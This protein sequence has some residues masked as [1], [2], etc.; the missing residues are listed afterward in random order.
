[1]SNERKYYSPEEIRNILN[2]EG[3]VYFLGIGG[4]SMSSLAVISKNRGL[5]VGGSDRCAS[6]ITKDLEKQGI[7]FQEGHIVNNL[8]NYTVVVY[9]AAIK[10][11]NDEYSYAAMHNYFM[12]YRSDYLGYVISDFKRSIGVAGTHGKSTATAM[13]FSVLDYAG[14]APTVMNG[15]VIPSINSQYRISDGDDIVF[16]ACE[17]KDSFLSF[18]PQIA[19]VLNAEYDHADYFKDFDV[20]IESFRKYLSHASDG[21]A[22]VNFDCPGARC[23]AEGYKGTLYSYGINS[24][25]AAVTAHNISFSNG[26]PDFDIHVNGKFYSHISLS[27]YGMHNVYNALASACCALICGINDGELFARAVSSFGGIKRR[28]ELC[29]TLNGARVYDDY[30][31]HPTE[32][33][34]TLT[35]ARKIAK[36]RVIGVFQPHTYSRTKALLDDFVHSLSACDD[37]VIADIYPARETDTLGMS[38]QL[39][40][41]KIPNGKYVGSFSHIAEYL[42][43]TARPDDVIVIMGAGDINTVISILKRSVK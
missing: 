32:I 2:K 39:I 8:T 20:Y 15:A 17:Y 23:A 3:N 4:V 14:A 33:T 1:M 38:A 18:F 29:T 24:A 21:Y 7:Q 43:V 11:D 13:I 22:V 35:A 9:N 16:E 41:D 37:V 28:F 36:G 27:V 42:T 40:A 26:T 34:A 30:A 5:R 12:I 6:D 25:D 19:V 10:P 31:H